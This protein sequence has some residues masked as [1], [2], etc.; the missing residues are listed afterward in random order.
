MKT[1]NRTDEQGVVVKDSNSEKVQS[2]S[3]CQKLYKES[4]PEKTDSKRQETSVADDAKLNH[5]K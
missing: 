1:L 4:F 5:H 3:G 2:S